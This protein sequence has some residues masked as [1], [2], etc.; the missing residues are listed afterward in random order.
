MIIF[1]ITDKDS[2]CKAYDRDQQIH[3]SV[4]Y[5]KKQ[6]NRSQNEENGRTH[7]FHGAVLDV[8]NL[9]HD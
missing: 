5:G 9:F 3:P 8:D 4:K 6:K 2:S 1:K 7:I